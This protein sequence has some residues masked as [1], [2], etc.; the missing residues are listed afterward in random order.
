MRAVP[1]GCIALLV[2][3]LSVVAAS[4]CRTGSSGVTFCGD[5]RR[6]SEEAAT[7]RQSAPDLEA[8][9]RNAAWN[10]TAQ[11]SY[12]SVRGRCA[13]AG[14]VTPWVRVEIGNANAG[15]Y[16]AVLVL[17]G[18]SPVAVIAEPRAPVRQLP[19]DRLQWA[20]LMQLAATP[21]LHSGS[22]PAVS[23][24]STY[25]VCARIG[26]TTTSFV[27]HG[28]IRGRDDEFNRGHLNEIALTRAALDLAR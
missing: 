15:T 19:I 2:A 17:G 10:W 21:G 16:Q 25:F 20:E 7:E 4:S 14:D 3:A 26:R 12:V 27:L 6:A 5:L 1:S 13:Q 24:G 8:A 9:F 23:D 11:Q 28:W 22:N 18:P